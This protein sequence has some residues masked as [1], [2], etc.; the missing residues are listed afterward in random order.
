MKYSESYILITYAKGKK[1]FYISNVLQSLIIF[2]IVFAIFELISNDEATFLNSLITF[3]IVAVFL[4]IV[5]LLFIYPN[6]WKNIE[7]QYNIIKNDTE[8]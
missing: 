1:H 5:S 8:L 3:I 2:M 4:N 7:R 6:R